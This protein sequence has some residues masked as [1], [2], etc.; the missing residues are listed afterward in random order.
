MQ[1]I[2]L[3]LPQADKQLYTFLNAVKDALELLLI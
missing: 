3:V 2:Q 1:S